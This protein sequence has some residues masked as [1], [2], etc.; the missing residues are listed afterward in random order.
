MDNV[1]PR[2]AFL[3]HTHLPALMTSTIGRVDEIA[4]LVELLRREEIRLV[5]LTGPGGVGKTRLGL[6]AAR[7]LHTAFADG[8]FFVSLAPLRE[9]GQVVLAIAQAVG[10]EESSAQPLERRLYE[11]LSNKHCLLLLDNFEHLLEIASL[12]SELLACVPR[13]TIL[14]TSREMLHIYGECEIIVPALALPKITAAGLSEESAAMSLFVERARAVKPGFILKHENQ[15]AIAE[16]C[17]QLDGLPLAIELAAARCKL[18]SPQAILTRLSNRLK[19]LTGGARDLPERQRTLRNTLDWSY[20]LLNLEEQQFFR[21]LGVFVGSWTLEAAEAAVDVAH[22]D[23]LYLLTSLVDKSLVRVVDESPTETRFLL[24]ET[25]REYALACLSQQGEEEQARRR[26]ASFYLSLAQDVEQHLQ[27]TGQQE[28]LQRLDREAANLWAALRWSIGNAEATIALPLASALREYLPLRSSL[29]EGRQWFEEVL[30]LEGAREASVARAR[31]LYG[32]GVLARIHSNLELART[33]LEES[34]DI[35]RQAGDQHT[36]ALVLGLLARLALYPGNYIVA[37]ELV[38]EGL[39]ATVDTGNQWCRG[40]LHRIYGNVASKQGDFATAST[41]YSLSLMLL[42]EAGDRRNEAETLVNLGSMM[43]L[44][45]KLRTAHYLYAR[46]L[47][48]LREL[49]DRWGQLACLNCMGEALRA[50][51]DYPQARACFEEG[52][53]LAGLLGDRAERAAA[54]TG[55]GQI[56]LCLGQQ[57]Q[58]AHFLKEALHIAREIKYTQGLVMALCGLGDLERIQGDW[59][60]AASYYRQGLEMA[61]STGDKLMMINLLSS[62]GDTARCQQRN[63][64]ACAQLKQSLHLAWEVGNHVA[65]SM[66]MEALAWLCVQAGQPEHGVLLL[67]AAHNL[68]EALQTPRAPVY[69]DAYVRDLAALRTA[70]GRQAF[71]ECWAEG[72]SLL[73]KQVMALAV[74]RVHISEPSPYPREEKTASIPYNLT[75]RELDVLRLLAEGHADARIAKIL[76][77]SPRTINTHL[78][79]IYAKLGVSSRSAATRIAITQ[80]LV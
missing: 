7:E 44:R 55:L 6:E 68:R 15:R 9:Q 10:V 29:S 74:A 24:L 23:P 28:G 79:S 66:G 57:A 13:L 45:G 4:A 72:R 52:L 75:A 60:S 51:A 78:R 38:E 63:A 11:Y 30:A 71:E 2:K 77:V 21:C 17:V 18:L 35:A 33:R 25:I 26:H 62:M 76:V 50:Q 16:I 40:I 65:L 46:G 19:L 70:V 73:L 61:Q 41:R 47:H 64:L 22:L 42:R 14:A 53:A 31:V 1:P 49:G 67:G 27:G 20:D 43:H 54:L 36:L 37:R 69:Q 5:T 8:V 34:R 3:T 39:Q 59:S 12:V 80:N 56:A 48:L 58:A 32:A